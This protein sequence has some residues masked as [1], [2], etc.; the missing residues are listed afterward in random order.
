M[1]PRTPTQAL[2]PPLMPDPLARLY[3]I[4]QQF[5][6][7]HLSLV[8]LPAQINSLEEENIE[9]GN[10]L[11]TEAGLAPCFGAQASLA[12]PSTPTK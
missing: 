5:T 8:G 3:A 6:F 2:I 11:R 12:E 9:T 7:F 10:P 1:L 4:N